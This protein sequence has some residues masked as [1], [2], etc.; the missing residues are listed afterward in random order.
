[1]E[2]LINVE[3]GRRM[4]N[5]E[6]ANKIINILDLRN[7]KDLMA[8]R[9]SVVKLMGDKFDEYANK[10]TKEAMIIADNYW[11]HLSAITAIIDTMIYFKGGEL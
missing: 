10:E 4:V 8:V 7:Q 3:V 2:E 5:K 1:M 6:N 9:N 11:N